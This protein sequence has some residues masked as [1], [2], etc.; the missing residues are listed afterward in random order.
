MQLWGEL[1]DDF[2]SRSWRFLQVDNN[3]DLGDAD[4]AELAPP[5]MLQLLRV[6]ILVPVLCYSVFWYTLNGIVDAN[7]WTNMPEGIKRKRLVNVTTSLIHSSVSG[8]Y[9]LIFLLR[10]PSLMFAAPM[11]YYGYLD[12]HILMVTIGYFIYDAIDLLINDKLSIQT[13]VLLFHHIAAVLFI[14]IALAS[15]KFV[16][17]AYWALLMEVSSVFLH[18][19]SIFHFSKMSTNP[20][21]SEV[22]KLVLIGNLV[23]F[24]AFRFSVQAWMVIWAIVNRHNMHTFYLVMAIVAM[25]AFFLINMSLFLRI[26]YSD[27]FMGSTKVSRKQLDA[28]LEDNEYTALDQEGADDIEELKKDPEIA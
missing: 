18:L 4:G 9:F 20:R 10:F 12:T 27:G 26:L 11:N 6:D 22:T 14:S 28:L 24:I 2:Y 16:L 5:A 13:G 8:F 21:Y 15:H 19:R 17:F 1:L 3:T 23:C 25:S 7:F